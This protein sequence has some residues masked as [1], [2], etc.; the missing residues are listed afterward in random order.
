MPTSNISPRRSKRWIFYLAGDLSLKSFADGRGLGSILRLLTG[1][2]ASIGQPAEERLR[3]L[4]D[5]LA[6]VLPGLRWNNECL[7]L[8]TV[9]MPERHPGPA[10]ISSEPSARR[11][12]ALETLERVVG[13]QEDLLEFAGRAVERGQFG[14]AER[15]ARQAQRQRIRLRPP[16]SKLSPEFEE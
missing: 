9:P 14:H 4:T 8:A 2:S 16:F 7:V 15:Y 13:A 1:G 12:A 3:T 5:L 6:D 10:R 11:L